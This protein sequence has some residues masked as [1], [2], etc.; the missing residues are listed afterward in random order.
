MAQVIKGYTYNLAKP[1]LAPTVKRSSLS[2]SNDIDRRIEHDSAR[3]L[4]T[5]DED[6][7]RPYLAVPGVNLAFI[8]PLGV[9]G[10]EI[11]DQAD[12]GKHKYLGTDKMDVDIVHG[13][14]TSISMSGIFPGWTAAANL[15]ALRAVFYAR[16]TAIGKIL[17]LPYIFQDLKY[18]ICDNLRHSRPD[19][20]RLLDISYSVT[21][22]VVGGAGDR[23]PDQIDTPNQIPPAKIGGRTAQTFSSTNAVNSLRK[24]AQKVYGNSE[25]WTDLYKLNGAWF[26]TRNIPSHLVPDYRLPT[27]TQ[28]SY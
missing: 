3:Y 8:W 4:L 24:I 18:V 1:P 15:R 2:A 11:A 16:S 22:V 17:N 27:G 20:E 25:R 26:D 9:E 6:F 7:S 21:F 19:D 13:G 12:L 14:E 10:F 23:S 5:P 28:I